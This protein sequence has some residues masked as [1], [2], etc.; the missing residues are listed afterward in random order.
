M[1]A[2]DPH[3]SSVLDNF[4]RRIAIAST[5]TAEPIRAGLAFW[6]EEIN[7]RAVIDFAPYNQVFQQLLDPGSLLA[8]NRNGVNVVLLR[9]EDWLRF[10]RDSPSCR[11][12]EEFLEQNT[13]H[14][15]DAVKTATTRSAMPLIV[16]LCPDSPATLANPDIHPMLARLKERMTTT[17]EDLAGLCLIR[18]DDF[19]LYPV[20]VYHDPQRD[21]LGHV[22]YTPLFYAALATMLARKLNALVSIPHKVIV[23]DCDNTLWKGVIAEEGINGITIP[24]AW[25]QLQ[26]YMVE[27]A[28]NGFLLCLCSKNDQADVLEVLKQHPDMILRQDHLISWRI[29]WQPKSENIRALAQELNLG[30]D[31]FVFL[32]DNPVE[33]A[34]VRAAC[35][36]VLTLQL[37]IEGDMGRFL[38]HI[39]AFDRHRV[40]FEDRQRTAMYKQEADRN[41]FQKQALTIEEFLKGLDLRVEIL[42]ALPLHLSRIAQ[43]TQRTNQ[44]NF[45]TIRRTD[46]EIQQLFE[47][48]LECRVVEVSDR[49]GDYGLVGVMIFAEQ[50]DA[51]EIDTF[52]LSCRVLGR[53]V[54]HQMLKELGKI[55]QQ[56][57]LCYVKATVLTTRKNQPARDFLASVASEFCAGTDKELLYRIPV[58]KAGVISYNPKALPA[59]AETVVEIPNGS[60]TA[61]PHHAKSAMPSNKSQQFERIANELALPEQVLELL[62]A[63][64][65]CLQPRSMQSP[66]PVAPQTETEAKLAALWARLLQFDSVGIHD[67]FFALGG[68]SLLAVDLFAEI[69]QRFGKRLPLTLL[70]EAPSL[71]QLARR[72]DGTATQNL[73]VLIRAGDGKP[74]LFL[75]HDGDGETMLYRNLALRLNTDH[76][77]YG[78]QPYSREDVPIA[79][80]RIT[81]M[82]AYYADKIQSV[83]P[84][85]PYMVGGMCAGGVI[86]FEI[87][88]QLQSR[89]EAVAIV[90]VLDAADV[91]ARPKTWHATSQRF[92]SFSTVF[93]QDKSIHFGRMM[94][95][96]LAGILRKV[97]NVASYLVKRYVN[98]LRDEV[99]MR[100]FRMYLD[101]NWRLPR[102]LKQIPVRVVYLFAEKEYHPN[103]LFNGEIALFRATYGH[104]PDEP[105]IERY[106][107]PLLGWH[108]RATRG[109]RAHNVPGGHS[110]MLQE[111][112]VNGLAEQMQASITEALTYVRMQKHTP[113]L[114][115]SMEYCNS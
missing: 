93:R 15:I 4:P 79:H 88:L 87:A 95:T 9:F 109:V 82:A 108:R 38:R 56:R 39:W 27:L 77:V 33:C 48:G 113:L 85:G 84:C 57:T 63:R 99:R 10:Y 42:E 114:A 6:L 90:A 73:P 54:E 94:L 64:V 43:L 22:P 14:L 24:P 5:F 105:Y 55:A 23:L 47:S 18:P 34:E 74:P 103:G 2:P 25:K 80:T 106:T 86:A 45:T 71:Q 100:L 12:H 11:S 101:R 46:R 89:G 59:Q 13:D 115:D 102:F 50:D 17:L 40:T 112:Y 32:D 75:V 107:D 16:A 66:P 8:M 21:R 41:R 69:E 52:L 49:F 29:N 91:A 76:A 68:T 110:S 30:Q 53:G 72:V 7:L 92:H 97:R 51:I 67:N 60:V 61:T 81:E 28:H 26:Q 104:G 111:P 37:P 62:Q 36:D 65:G 83:R 78:L 31:S 3:P 19:C 1:A 35:P 98:G 20:D 96:I 44:F 70:I 58:A